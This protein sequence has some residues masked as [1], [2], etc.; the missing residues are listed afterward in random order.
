[1]FFTQD[2][3][4]RSLNYPPNEFSLTFDDGP[5]VGVTEDLAWLLRREL[6]AAT[7]FVLGEHANPAALS[8]VVRCGHR[9]GNH[10][11]SH[12]NM[13]NFRGDHRAEIARQIGDCHEQIAQFILPRHRIPFRAPGGAWS[14]T[15]FSVF[16][17]NL[18]NADRYIGRYGW[19]IDANDWRLLRRRGHPEKI[20]FADYCRRFEVALERFRGGIVL[21]H[22]GFPKNEAH[23]DDPRENR[24]LDVARFVI[25]VMRQR[26]YRCVPLKEPAPWREYLQKAKSRAFGV[27]T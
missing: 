23:L 8:T 27:L 6:V 21:L 13:D 3:N 18:G 17:N 4:G 10:T 14:D 19:D 2:L 15:R 25:R 20:G 9:L 24:V 7:F 1:M 11:F 26:G 16:A 5:T 12:Q 22:D